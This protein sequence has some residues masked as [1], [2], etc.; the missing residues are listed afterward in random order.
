MTE[1]SLAGAPGK[2]PDVLLRWL[3]ETCGGQKA[4]I[5]LN[6]NDRTALAEF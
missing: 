4:Y 2:G 5:K 3:P 1:N 6:A